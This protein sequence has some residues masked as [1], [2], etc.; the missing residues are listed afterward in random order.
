MPRSWP[1]TLQRLGVMPSFSRPS[2]SDDNP[3]SE[4]LFRTLKYTPAYPDKPFADVQQARLWVQ[5]F[6]HWYN[7]EHCHSAIRFVTPSQRHAGLDTAILQ[8]R[9]DT[10]TR[11]RSERPERWNG[12][13][14][15]NW[16]PVAQ[17]WLNPEPERDK[18]TREKAP[19]AA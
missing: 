12:R 14:T 2:V 10:Y 11:A 19:K 7:K 3:Y 16:Q 5:R 18:P 1:A 4:A 17:V 8:Q 9:H 15:R 13:A 6:V